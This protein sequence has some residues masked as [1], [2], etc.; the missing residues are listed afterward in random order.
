MKYWGQGEVL[1]KVDRKASAKQILLS[2]D[3][4]ALRGLALWLFREGTFQQ[5]G[6]Q[7]LRPKARVGLTC[8]SHIENTNMAG[9]E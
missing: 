6:Q 3:L 2:K 4:K 7:V 8:S 5:E 9:T 1:W